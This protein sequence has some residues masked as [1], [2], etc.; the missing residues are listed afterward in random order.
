MASLSGSNGSVDPIKHI[1]LYFDNTDAEGTATKL[2]FAL[3]ED[4]EHSDGTLAFTRFTDGITNNTE[5]VRPPRTDLEVPLSDPSIGEIRAHSILAKHKLAPPLLAHF[6][7]GLL[8]RYCEGTV[9]MPEDLRRPEVYQAV[10]RRLAEWH[11]TLP[12][13]AISSK[14]SSQYAPS[15]VDSLLGDRQSS[16]CTMD[17]DAKKSSKGNS[18]PTPNLWAVMQKWIT[19]LPADTDAARQRKEQLQEELEWLVKELSDTLGIGESPYVFSHC[20]LLS[21]NVIIMP[22]SGSKQPDAGE[23]NNDTP[24]LSVAFIDYEYATPAPAVFD[25]SNHFAEWGG[26][27]CDH[28]ALPTKSQRIDFLRHYLK[29]Y[30]E[31]SRGGN[32][33]P[34]ATETE[35][36]ELN[37]EI[38]RFRGVPGF[39]WG[40]WALIQALISQIDFD[41][42]SYAEIRLSEYW[43]WKEA[44]YGQNRSA[45][46]IVG[47]ER[48]LRERRWAQE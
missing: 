18:A 3:F 47:K 34:Q 22:S 43:A 11:A 46:D 40:I 16:D 20:D 35:L 5:S 37:S 2:A 1:P 36:Q 42:A 21:G 12:V 28:S 8:Y 19:A 44:E 30:N 39:Y 14:S 6:E 9:C 48:P 33:D 4:W 41:Y 25:I 24:D 38:N 7:N 17:G 26:F 31:H 27:D 23:S 45:E 13:S 29:S 32:L 15:P 10:A